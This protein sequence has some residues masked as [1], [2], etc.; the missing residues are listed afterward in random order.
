MRT[1]KKTLKKSGITSVWTVFFLKMLDVFY[2][3]MRYA[4]TFLC[5]EW[6]FT[7]PP[8]P[9]PSPTILRHLNP[10]CQGPIHRHANPH[11]C[12]RHCPIQNV[13]STRNIDPITRLIIT[14]SCVFWIPVRFQLLWV[15]LL[16]STFSSQLSSHRGSSHQKVRKNSANC[17]NVSVIT[18]FT[19]YA[20]QS[21][22]SGI[23]STSAICSSACTIDSA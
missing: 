3:I 7:S 17:T 1:K 20:E 11:F 23:Q 8:S 5:S 4:I 12:P 22:I 16:Q 9:Q 6:K 2:A 14:S 10:T 15:S 19:S 18:T 13:G 21:V